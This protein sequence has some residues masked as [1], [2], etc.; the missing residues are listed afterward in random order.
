MAIFGNL[1]SSG[2]KSNHPLGSDANVTDLIAGFTLADP[3][4][5]LQESGEWLD[6]FQRFSGEIDLRAMLRA[7]LRLD[8]VAFPARQVLLDRYLDPNHR[9]HLSELIWSDIERGLRQTLGA[10]RHCLEAAG[11]EPRKEP[12]SGSYRE[13]LTLALARALRIYASR[14]KLL[15]FRY[16]GLEAAEWRELHGILG[17]AGRF[18][19]AGEA[20]ANYESDT[21]KITPLQH[22]L[23]GIYLELAPLT[24]LAAPQMEALDRML[25][26]NTSLLGLATGAG[27]AASHKIDLAG[28]SG[29]IPADRPVAGGGEWR[30][31]SRSRLRP[32]V[33]KLAMTLRQ[34]PVVPPDLAT[35]GLTLDQLKRLLTTLMLH[36]AETPPHRGTE[37]SPESDTLRA[38]TGFSLAR[39]MIAYSDFARSGRSIEYTGSNLQPLFEQTR[40]G[41]LASLDEDGDAPA[42]PP[43][44]EQTNPLEVL[45]RLELAGDKQMM[46]S[47]SLVD[48]SESGLGVAAPGLKSKYHI[49]SLVCVRNSEGIDWHVGVIR[50]IGRDAAGHASIGLET[51]SWPASSAKV[52]ASGDVAASVWSKLE[53]GSQGLLDAILIAGD[54]NKLVLPSGAFAADLQLELISG[55]SQRLIRLT[56]LTETGEDFELVRFVPAD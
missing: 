32:L 25:L 50:R 6:D 44:A 47:W 29:P 2:P 30:Y 34:S 13:D 27:G 5:V 21:E 1:F 45:E 48:R 22:Y 16:R 17:L 14:K 37:R 46:E 38:V 23:V 3:L 53:Q 56:E 42:P 7:A 41:G 9:E 18:G 28:A 36:W 43:E 52:R 10:Y 15:R 26:A 35:S 51:L 55:D 4:R 20:V 11:R 24:N 8:A 12:V 39:R 31:L 19:C 40:F 49:G 54:G 33:T